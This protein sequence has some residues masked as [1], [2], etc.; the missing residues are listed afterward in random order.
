LA[1]R[2]PL[3]FKA[4]ADLDHAGFGEGEQLIGIKTVAGQQEGRL[5]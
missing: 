5:R 3:V 2:R 4:E 1:Q